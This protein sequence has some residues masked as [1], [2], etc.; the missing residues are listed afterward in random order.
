MEEQNIGAT[1]KETIKRLTNKTDTME[2]IKLKILQQRAIQN[3][4]TRT[5]DANT[6][7]MATRIGELNFLHIAASMDIKKTTNSL[8]QILEYKKEAA[9]Q[10]LRSSDENQM[11]TLA[12]IIMQADN[13][14]KQVLGMYE[15]CNKKITTHDL[16]EI[17]EARDERKEQEAGT[18]LNIP[19]SE[20]D[21]KEDFSH[22]NGN[23]LCKCCLCKNYFYGH[24]RR[25]VCKLCLTEDLSNNDKK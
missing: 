4:I 24:K 12:G 10:M 9:K 13:M 17:D 5:S 19:F 16:R 3:V 18:I 8:N 2:E 20:R 6:A 22:E 7:T 25:P 15:V 14:I 1:D 21:W 11:D 23:Y